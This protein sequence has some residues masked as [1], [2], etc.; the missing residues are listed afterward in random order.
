MA[1]RKKFIE[2]EI[3]LINETVAVAGTPESLNK[4]TIKID[5]SRKLRGK[6]LDIKFQIFNKEGK[7]TAH[8]KKIEIMGSYIQ[9]TTRKHT[10][11]VEDSFEAKCADIRARIKPLFV[12]RKKVSRAVKNNLRKTAKEWLLEKTAEK[13]FIRICEDILHG[14]LQRDLLP[15]LK[16]IYPL[17]FCDIRIIE[18]KE[19]EKA[20]FGEKKPEKKEEVK[21]KEE[22]KPKKERKEK[23]TK[24]ATKASTKG[25][26]GGPLK[27]EKPKAKEKIEKGEGEQIA[28]D[29][30]KIK[31]KSDLGKKVGTLPEEKPTPKK[32][33]SE[34]KK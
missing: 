15:K 10:S 24:E 18:T 13:P 31:S 3:P 34:K 29:K 25:E 26:V 2:V 20:D 12:T 23:K 22:E 14:E 30:S 4:K 16:K 33:K 19:L 6:N 1:S 32:T 17:A 28:L 7:L 5:M 11:Y 8:P 21:P 27:E 9:R